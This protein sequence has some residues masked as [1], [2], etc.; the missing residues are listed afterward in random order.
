MKKRVWRVALVVLAMLVAAVGSAY[1]M[2][3]NVVMKV[4]RTAQDSVVN[5]GEDLTID[6]QLDGV[7]PAMYKWYFEDTLI[8]DA[9]DRVY[10]I[11]RAEVEDAGMYRMEAFGD[12]GA[13]LVSMEFAVRVIEDELPQAGDNTLSIGLV[14]GIMLL[15]AAAMAAAIVRS[16]RTVQEL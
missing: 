3:A 12:D 1:A 9:A 4:S 2:S 7:A 6:V 5:A 13:M 11:R 15:S 10:T 16:R 8:D 14:S